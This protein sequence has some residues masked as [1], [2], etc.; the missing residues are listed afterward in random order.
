MGEMI[1]ERKCR[2]GKLLKLDENIRCAKCREAL[3]KIVEKI[4]DD[5]RTTGS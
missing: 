5:E 3:R 4:N 2:C 1:P